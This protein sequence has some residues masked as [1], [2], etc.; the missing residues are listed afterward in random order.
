MN[1]INMAVLI[2]ARELKDKFAEVLASENVQATLSYPEEELQPAKRWI[3][4]GWSPQSG[5]CSFQSLRKKAGRSSKKF[6]T[7]ICT[8][9]FPVWAWHF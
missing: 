6:C 3:F 2:V 9:A 7:G 1:A 8:S 4:W 5:W